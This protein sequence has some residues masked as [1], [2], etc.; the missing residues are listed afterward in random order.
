MMNPNYRVLNLGCGT[1]HHPDAV[2]V[3]I[4]SEVDPDEIQDLEEE[5]WPWKS[6][7]FDAI[8]ATHLLEHI[9]NPVNFMDEC[10]RILKPD[11]KLCLKVPYYQH[12]TAFEDPTHCNFFTE[13][14][15]RMFT[16]SERSNSLTQRTWEIT[17]QDFEYHPRTDFPYWHLKKWLNIETVEPKTIVCHLSPSKGD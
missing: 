11:G 8:I 2:N 13:D 1:D 3:D 14:S 10:W 6:E 17:L 9:S 4:R 15:F 12:K 5:N 7:E 16:H